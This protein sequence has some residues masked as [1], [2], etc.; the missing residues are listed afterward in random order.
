MMI[1]NPSLSSEMVNHVVRPWKRSDKEEDRGV[2]YAD[3]LQMVADLVAKTR[4]AD[5]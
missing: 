2:V 4:L 5:R 3:C 1:D